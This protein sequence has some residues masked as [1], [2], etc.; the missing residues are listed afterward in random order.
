MNEGC[1]GKIIRIVIFAIIGGVASYLAATGLG[2]YVLVAML[3][4]F[5]ISVH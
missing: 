2:G 5:I 1:T 3:L 4:Y